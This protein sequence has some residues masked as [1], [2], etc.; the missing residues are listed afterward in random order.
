MPEHQLDD[1]RIPVFAINLKH[2]IDRYE[3]IKQEFLGKPEFNV[4]I[5]EGL[6]HELKTVSLWQT[7]KGIIRSNLQ[8][9]AD[10]II[11]CEDDH[12]FTD[13]YNPSQLLQHIHEARVCGADIL[14]GGISSCKNGIR[15]SNSLFW[16]ERFT[17]LQFS[18]IFKK[19]FPEILSAHFGE[20]DVADHKIS[21]L[22]DKK[23]VVHPFI[24]IQKEFGYSDVTV[25]NNN[26]GR[27]EQLFKDTSEKLD[28]LRKVSEFYIK[29]NNL[30]ESNR[31]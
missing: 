23:F 2:R 20:Y 11:I 14:C 19:F 17:G 25:I 30:Y 24:S 7:I 27:V 22:T 26:T 12:Q 13:H 21:S 29:K 16:V 10:F 5:V 3:S 18:V 28:I 6:S 1:A 8:D 31:L 4:E 15:I 9:T